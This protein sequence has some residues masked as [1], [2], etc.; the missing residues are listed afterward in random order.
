M[1]R[2]L[3]TVI[4]TFRAARRVLAQADVA[5][6][7]GPHPMSLV[8]LL[9]ARSLH[10][11]VV[12]GVR[13]DYARYLQHRLPRRGRV[14]P[15]LRVFDRCFSALGGHGSVIAVGSSMALP[16]QRGGRNVVILPVSLVTQDQLAQRLGKEVSEFRYR[17]LSVGR[18]DA[19]KNPQL[20]LTTLREL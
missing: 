7:F 14:R 6:I 20:L 10:L 4:G 19:E 9:A 1:R 2:M 13:Q 11:P 15:L 8:I 5:L 12:L 18:L 17:V 16:Y 3:L